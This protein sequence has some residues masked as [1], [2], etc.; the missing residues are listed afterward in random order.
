MAKDYYG[1]LGIGRNADDKE[2]KSAYRK[3]A[4]K[5]HPDV[6]PNDK[7]AEAKFKEVSEA[8]EVL[9]D[10]EKR[11]LYDQFGANWDQVRMGGPGGAAGYEDFFGGGGVAGSPFETIFEQFF[12]FGGGKGGRV[13]IEDLQ[14]AQ[15]RDVEKTVEVS[16]EEVDSGTRRSLTYQTMDAVQTRDGEITT[17]PSTKKVEITIPAGIADG[18]KLRVPGKGA[19]GLNGRSGDLFVVIRWQ[20]HPQFKPIG[21]NL[22]VEVPVPYTV[23]A[24]GGEVRVQ[25]LRKPV[26][27]TI[28]AGS[29]SGQTFRLG[30][31]GIAK[32]GGGRGN[33]MARIRITVPKSLSPE[34]KK[35]LKQ[36]QD[37]EK[38]HA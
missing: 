18:K 16:L 32:L 31:Q 35:L 38:V 19:T 34:E 28:P 21:E 9:S 13:N 2:I 12:H 30:G 1:A 33:L 14:T 15:P 8:Y 11:K 3:L 25:T 37:L 27:M 4:R 22:E 29:Q 20:K 36:L 10:P 24:L 6:N 5:Y 7:A 26:S 17:V 23:A